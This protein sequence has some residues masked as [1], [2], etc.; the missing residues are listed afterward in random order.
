M[1]LNNIDSEL[2]D[3]RIELKKLREQTVKQRLYARQ[4][5]SYGA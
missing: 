2:N 3:P 1:L 4:L 5:T